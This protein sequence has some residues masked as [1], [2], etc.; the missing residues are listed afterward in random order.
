MFV[1]AIFRYLREFFYR[2]KLQDLES[3]DFIDH[4]L[5][6][7]AKS[8]SHLQEE[9]KIRKLGIDIPLLLLIVPL[10][11]FSCFVIYSASNE[12]QNYLNRHIV[13]FLIGFLLMISLAN[14]SFIRLLNYSLFLYLGLVALLVFVY[15][16][17]REV[18]G[19]RRW[20]HL[21]LFNIQPSEFA[22]LIIPLFLTWLLFAD[23]GILKTSMV[24][25]T[26]VYTSIVVGLVFIQPDLGTSIIISFSGLLILF[27]AGIKW[28]WIFACLLTLLAS[29]PFLWIYVIKTYQKQRILTLLNP[30]SDIFGVGWHIV[31]AKIAIGSGG[32]FGKG[33]LEGSQARLNFLPESHTDFILAVLGEEFGLFG[34]ICLF[35]LYIAIS[36]RSIS[37]ISSC[38]EPRYLPLGYTIISLFL[39]KLV[40]NVGMVIGL[41]PVVGVT[42]P[43]FS[44]GGSSLIS[45][46]LGFGLIMSMSKAR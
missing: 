40:I 30:E 23:I 2:F 35:I 3:S 7:K 36:M 12:S 26:L 10:F 25:K 42:L 24:R 27:F 18:N 29:I 22:S 39:L 14:F 37:L 16:F 4:Y 21:F 1:Q 6:S 9:V 41:L 5:S 19:S 34:I 33:F 46:M 11:V 17:G 13:F 45:L 32:F 38:Y 15:F 43:M 44:Y 28:R 31:Q 8:N 20:V